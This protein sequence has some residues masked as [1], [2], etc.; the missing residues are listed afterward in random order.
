MRALRSSG[1]S[2]GA[3]F[4]VAGGGVVTLD[5]L[6]RARELASRVRVFNGDGAT[7]DGHEV[8]LLANVGDAAGARSAAEAGA[9]KRA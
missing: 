1:D 4:T 8:Q 7:K 5:A 6:R 9:I 2:F 3:R